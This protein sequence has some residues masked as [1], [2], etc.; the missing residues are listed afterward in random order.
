MA[1]EQYVTKAKLEFE[2]GEKATILFGSLSDDDIELIIEEQS[3]LIDDFLQDVKDVPFADIA[4][5]TAATLPYAVRELCLTFCKYKFW[6]RRA[7]K[8]IPESLKDEY[9]NAV[10]LIE[11][12]QNGKVTIGP[13]E[14]FSTEED[15][16][17]T[18]GNVGAVEDK[19][20]WSS[21]P[22]KLNVDM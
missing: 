9:K 11:K 3:R 18:N 21:R 13:A 4:T 16:I 22:R 15:E 7:V 17:E 14:D 19:I 10:K 1:N 2:L 20:R 5:G 6:N 8:D 12:I